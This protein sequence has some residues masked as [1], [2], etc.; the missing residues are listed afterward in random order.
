MKWDDIQVFLAA[1]HAGSTAG[2][3]RELGLNQSTVSR[4]LTALETELG[5]R[6]FDRIPGGLV[7]TTSALDA[8]ASAEAMRSAA[9]RLTAELQDRDQRV[10]GTV[11]VAMFTQ[12]A[13][14][15]IVPKLPEL[16]TAHPGLRIE[17]VESTLVSDLARREADLAVRLVPPQSGDLVYKRIGSFGFGVYVSRH[18]SGIDPDRPP[19]LDALRWIRWDESMSFLP[20][21][22]WQRQVA[23]SAEVVLTSMDQGTILT[24]VEAGL[25]AAV[26]AVPLAGRHPELVEIHPGS[27]ADL[28]QPIYL[29]A[30]RALRHLPRYDVV[31]RFIAK[32]LAEAA[33]E[34][35]R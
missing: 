16:L 17:F 14:A 23:P 22:R 15:F 20:E 13:R 2:A 18:A 35:A 34:A 21:S 30:H 10:A 6:L 19:S 7:P 4:R 26:L 33:E 5:F 31:W 3:A 12:L 27:V 24:A 28:S 29:V 9:H 1:F 25:G 8:L 32:L 11:R